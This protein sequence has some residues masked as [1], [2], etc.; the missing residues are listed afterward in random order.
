MKL[1]TVLKRKLGAK[2]ASPYW[3][4]DTCCGVKSTDSLTLRDKLDALKEVEAKDGVHMNECGYK[5]FAKNISITLEKIKGGEFGKRA[6]ESPSAVSSVSGCSHFW[7]GISSPVGST[8]KSHI[9]GWAKRTREWSHRAAGPY[10]R[11]SG[12]GGKRPH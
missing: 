8:S 2:V 1:R 9:P 7:R 12:R 4:M 10:D 6:S 3:V 11:N 5:N